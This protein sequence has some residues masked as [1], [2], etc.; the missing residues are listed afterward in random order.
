M[1]AC[2]QTCVTIPINQWVPPAYAV[3]RTGVDDQVASVRIHIALSTAVVGLYPWDMRSHWGINAP[4]DLFDFQAQRP[5]ES[6][7]DFLICER[8]QSR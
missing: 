2:K 1:S 5:H 8:L 3:Y 6:V 7:A 4:R